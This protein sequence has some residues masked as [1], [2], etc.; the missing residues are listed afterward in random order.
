MEKTAKAVKKVVKKA[1]VNAKKSGMTFK[2]KAKAAKPQK[3]I[4]SAAPVN[5]NEVEQT[6]QGIDRRSPGGARFDGKDLHDTEIVPEIRMAETEQPEAAVPASKPTKRFKLV[7][8]EPAA[9]ADL[10]ESPRMRTVYGQI[11]GGMHQPVEPASGEA[12]AEAEKT[13]T[14]GLRV[15][16][17]VLYPTKEGDCAPM[18]T[19]DGRCG[20]TT[21]DTSCAAGCCRKCDDKSCNARCAKATEEKGDG[22]VYEEAVTGAV[23]K[24]GKKG[25][26]KAKEE[27]PEVPVIVTVGRSDLLEA[28]KVCLAIAGSGSGMIPTLSHVHLA[29]SENELVLSVTSLEIA[30]TKVLTCTTSAPV[31]A[32]VPAK[33]LSQEIK[34]LPGDVTSIELQITTRP[35][36]RA[37]SIN[38]RCSIHG[39]DAAEF[40]ELPG[41]FDKIVGVRSLK[42]A[43]GRVMPAVS[44]DELRYALTGLHLN[45]KEGTAV[46]TDGF[47]LH[48][49]EIEASGAP[50]ESILLPSKAAQLVLKFKGEDEIHFRDDGRFVAFYVAGG[51]L[52]VRLIEGNYPDYKNVMPHPPVQV[53]FAAS[54]FLKLI[55]GAAPIADGYVCLCV[56]GDLLIH[57]SRD[58]GSYE[59]KIPAIREGGNKEELAYHFNPAFL[60]DAIKS[61]PA[62]RVR[63]GLPDGDYGPVLVNEKAVV[64]P[65]RV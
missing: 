50:V 57:A 49:S 24:G 19:A 32:L 48:I 38:G 5:V 1:A 21:G 60:V 13:V 40:P 59:W 41:G 9:P 2:R 52:L 27:E 4:A 39:M 23:V 17:F 29:A 44:K 15:G 35:D 7:K 58:L 53:T 64:M 43:M 14:E 36:N 45:F 33:V 31:V 26:G 3:P 46:G 34:A 20:H 42:E 12:Q 55:E 47:R 65:V 18:R 56:N 16:E 25:K 62:E 54:E 8:A 30:Y 11:E 6:A 28:L 51:F 10:P 22:L 63:L 37:V 61:Y